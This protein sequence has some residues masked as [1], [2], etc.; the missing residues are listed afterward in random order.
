MQKISLKNY[1][2]VKEDLIQK[3]IVD[4]PKVLELG[5][6]TPIQRE[7]IQSA[8]GRLDLLMSSADNAIRYEIEIQLGATDPR[9]IIKNNRI[10]GYREKTLSTV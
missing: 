7:R 4:N 6:L 8:G 10:W 1:P 3:F 2:E 5:E 9:H